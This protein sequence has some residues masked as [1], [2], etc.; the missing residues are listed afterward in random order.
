MADLTMSPAPGERLLRFVGDRVRFSLR[1]PQGFPSGARALLRTNLGKADRLRQEIIATHAGKNP[2]SV[3]F[4][5][6]IPLQPETNGEWSIE[7]PVT[8]VGFYRAKAYWIDSLG[9]QH[10]PDGA[11]AGISVHPNIYRTANT[12]YCAFIRLFGQTKT[13]VTTTD[14]KLESQLQKLDQQGYTVIPPSGKL[15]DLIK[16]LP[17]IIDTLGCRI[18]HLLP[19]NPT[20]TTYARF[21]RFGS[22]YACEDL[23]AIDPALVEFDQRT[24]GVEQFCELTRAV[25]RRRARVILD[26]VINQTGWGSTLQE[27][28]PDWF[29]RE[30]NGDFASPG[31]WGNTWADLVEL[32]PV[33]VEL[34]EQLAQAFLTWCRRGVD[35]FRCDAGYKVPVQVWQYIEARV[36]QEFPDT[37]FLLEGLGGPLESTE[38]LLTD[39]GMQWAYSELFQNYGPDIAPYLDYAQRQSSRVGVY[40]HYSETHDNNR[41]AV[42]GRAW[43]LLRNRLC[44]L[45]SVAGGFGFTCGVEW[46]A[47]EK[48]NVHGCRGLSWGNKDNLIPE[49]A[50]LNRLLANHPC[51]FDGAKL[52]RLSALDSPVYALQRDSADG[53]DRVLILINTDPKEKQTISITTADS[54]P[55]PPSDGGEGRGEEVRKLTHDLLGQP[56]PPVG[57]QPSGCSAYTLDP[58]ATYCLAATEKPNG[59][60]GDAYRRTRAQSA[61]AIAALSKTLLPEE[62]GPCNWCDLAARVCAD[63]KNF[64]GSL[65]YLDRAKSKT[66]LLTALDAANGN[67]PQVVTWTLLDRRRITPVPTNHWLLIRD[68]S[69]FRVTLKHNTQEHAESIEVADGHI[70]FFPPKNFITATDA[71]LTIERYATL[72]ETTSAQI[73]FLTAAPQIETTFSK[74]PPDSLVLLTNGRGGMARLCVDLGRINSKYDCAL[75]ANLN[76]DLPVDRHVFAKRIRVWVNA[77]GFIT[78]LNLQ[79][80]ASFQIGGGASRTREPSAP[81][82]WNFV[83]DAGDSRT[84]AIQ[85]TA[86]MLDGWNTTVFRFTRVSKEAPNFDIRLTVRVDIEDRNFHCETQRN[87]G[88]EAHFTAHCHPLENGFAFTPA[89]DRQFQAFVTSGIYHPEPEWCQAIPHPVEQSR[90][91]TGFGDAY[92]PGWFE[93][94]ITSVSSVTLVLSADIPPPSLAL[95]NEQNKTDDSKHGNTRNNI[96]PLLGGE[97]TASGA[98]TNHTDCRGEVEISP[99][100]ANI[101]DPFTAH[102]TLAAHAFIA[103]RGPGQTVIAGYPWF[104]DWGRDTFI[105]ARG[106]LS[107]G[108]IREVTNLLVTFGRFVENGTMPNTIHGADASNRDTSDAPLWYA[109][110]CEET[111]ALLKENLYEIPVGEGRARHSVRAG[112]SRNIQDVLREIAL[113][114][115]RGTPNGIRM[116]QESALIWSPSHFTWMDTNHPAGTPREGYPV[117]IQVL[118]IKLL[119]QLERLGAPSIRSASVSPSPGG[120]GRDEDELSPRSANLESWQ[121]LATRAEASLK[122]YYWLAKEGY[123]ADLLIAAP[124]TTAAHAIVDNALRPNSLLA[125]AFGQITGDQAR[126]AVDA[127]FRHLVIPG[128]IR[129]IAPLPVHPPLPI[130]RDGQLLNNPP[131]PYWGRYEGDEDTRRKPAYHNGTAW[132][133]PFPIACEALVK[134]WE[135][136][137]TA[138]AAAKSYLGSTDQLIMAGCLGQLPEILDGD[139]PHQQRGCD[140]QAWSVTETLRVW[141]SLNP[142]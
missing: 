23:T 80:L 21:G 58:S 98:T 120:E 118:W 64:L 27:N 42:Q 135:N 40:V 16:E 131:E 3:A 99:R 46:L 28:H 84:I 117:E 6:D 63:P 43:S 19:V 109:I 48:I 113:G 121:T 136:S 67:Y 76:P 116:D 124:G 13:A 49:L 55:S 34:W 86:E 127:A 36:H 37:L 101:S 17:H 111:A 132:V 51:F 78:P 2:M 85:L 95:L 53:K 106:L 25:H 41:L 69:P 94:P 24:T 56:M 66:D 8:D 139:A 54:S 29:L 93:L 114:Y 71:E 7:L 33:A 72:D 10:W 138:I 73:R 133:W 18:V 9:R 15:R 59:L 107:A 92:S 79:N 97:S 77:N 30:K 52:T 74:P 26:I 14:D 96:L 89:T 81:A 68:Q 100:S 126:R 22:P 50:R 20:P 11:D 57:V 130:Y 32:N 141:K 87:S 108:C 83:A 105:A 75:G 102:L 137:P 35:G 5:R 90:G 112:A 123:L 104:L 62:I 47:A 110:V 91:Q 44:A 119:R 125:V 38:S 88:A 39:G 82:V 134:A 142:S 65:T 12:I 31:A 129:T 4:W 45:T 128:A 61:W 122:K 103:K 60:T 1:L 115:L 140:A 70:A